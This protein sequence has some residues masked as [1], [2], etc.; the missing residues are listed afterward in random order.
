MIKYERDEEDKE[1]GFLS[2][3]HFVRWSFEGIGSFV[4]QG[5]LSICLIH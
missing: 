1:E 2:K 5:A 4:L 3:R